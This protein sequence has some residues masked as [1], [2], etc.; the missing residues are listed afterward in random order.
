MN[1]LYAL[2]FVAMDV[3]LTLLLAISA[4]ATQAIERASLKCVKAS[5]HFTLHLYNFKILFC[6]LCYTCRVSHL[7]LV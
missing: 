1:V 2:T 5:H 7:L 3:A 4:S 6:L